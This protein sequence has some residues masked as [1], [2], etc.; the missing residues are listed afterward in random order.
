MNLSELLSTERPIG[1]RNNRALNSLLYEEMAQLSFKVE[2]IPMKCKV[3]EF[4]PSSLERGRVSFD[5]FPGP[6][7]PGFEGVIPQLVPLASVDDLKAVDI[8]EKM[9]L[10]YGE[11]SKEPLMP[12][13]FP[14]YFP[15][16]HKVIY[17][18]LEKQQPSFILAATGQHP[19][20]GLD[21]FPLFEDGNFY[22]PNAFMDEK[23]ALALL[24][25]KG[26]VNLLLN[27]GVRN[28]SSQ[29]LIAK[30]EGQGKKKVVIGAHMDTKYGT[31]GAIDNGAGVKALIVI[32][33]LLSDYQ[34]KFSLEFVP[35]NGEEYYGASGELA[36]LDQQEV[37]YDQIALMVNLDGLGHKNAKVAVSYYNIDDEK[38]FEEVLSAFPGVTKGPAW[39]A[40]D[41]SMFA[42]QG[43]PCI[44]LTSS[45]LWD[46]VLSLTHTPLDTP[47]NLDMS[48]IME[49]A[50]F[51]ASIVRSLRH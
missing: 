33:R 50:E 29:Q 7:S 30:K 35:F 5:I 47:E 32:M 21:P 26:P 4:G 34:G 15:E 12:K 48:I 20:C 28:A 11:I 17:N 14:F 3:W 2:A 8:K 46:D 1:S 44:A 22:I 6:F 27:S 19:A 18:L 13:D 42:F 24:S 51:V 31:P 36:Y 10:L 41:H 49:A 9:A 23:S 16:E 37:S 39:Y 25:L 38:P 45:N 43:V 40:G